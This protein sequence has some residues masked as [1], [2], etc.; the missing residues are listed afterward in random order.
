MD[1]RI[2]LMGWIARAQLAAAVSN[3]GGVG[4]LASGAA[5]KP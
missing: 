1:N 5:A 4:Q 3:A 2:S